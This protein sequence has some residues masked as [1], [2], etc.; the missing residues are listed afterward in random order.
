MVLGDTVLYISV[1]LALAVFLALIYGQKKKV[2]TFDWHIK[3]LIRV[4]SALLFFDFVLLS[5]YFAKSNFTIN[6][7]WAFSS[8]HYPIYYRLSGALAGQQGTLLFWAALIAIGSLWLNETKGST[9][10][11][12]KK[13]QII[14]VFLVAYFA[15]L[16]LLDSPFKTIYQ[17]ASDL[18]A[19]FVPLDGNGLNP[20]L[21]DPWMALHPFTTF[22]AYAGTTIPLAGAIVYLLNTFRGVGEK[23]EDRMWV[24]K[25]MQW[26]RVSWLFA[27]MSMAMGGLWAYKSLGWGG[28]W[29][30]DPVE[31]AMFLPW[32]MLTAAIHTV[33]EHRRDR[34]KYNILAPI[35]VS[36]SFALVIYATMVTRSGI[37]ESV[38]SF[39]AGDVGK[40]IIVLTAVSFAIPL[41]LGVIKYL[42]TETLEREEESIVN[43]TNIFY[44][45]ILVFLIMTFI[46]FFGVTYPP[47]IKLLTTKKHAVTAQFFNIWIYPFFILMLLLIGLGLQYRPSNRKRAVSDFL[48]FSGLT[49]VVS[50]IKPNEY[51]NIVDYTAIVGPSKPLL[52]R[53]IGSISAL[54]VVPPSIYIVYVAVDRWKSRISP[55]TTRNSKIKELGILTIHIGV[56][57][58]SLGIVFASLFGSNFSVTL[59]VNDIGK[60]TNI[61]PAQVHEGFGRLGTWGVHE[62]EGTS[63]Y[64]VQ[65]LDY[66]EIEDYG[67][68]EKEERAPPPGIGISEFY[69]ELA[70][71]NFKDT[72]TVRGFIGDAINV[73][74]YTYIK[75]VEGEK[76]LWLAI[77]GPEVRRNINIVATGSAMFN[78][79]SP[80]LNRTFDVIIFSNHLEE[81]RPDAGGSPYKT[82]QQVKLA[83]YKH[84]GKIGEGVA[85]LETYE[86]GDARR[87]LIDM[88]LVRDVFV[89]FDG[90]GP[91]GAIPLTVKLKPLM[92]EIWL[93]VMLF[94][95]GI[96]M[97]I[98]TD[99]KG[100]A[101]LK[102]EIVFQDL[103][104]G[105]GGCAAVCPEKA[106]RVD[107]FPKLIGECT[108]CSY[109]LLQ[110]PRRSFD[111]KG[112][113]KKIHGE[114]SKDLLGHT[115]V[116]VGARG[117]DPDIRKGA[118]DGAFVTTLLKYA[119]EK[120]II[121]G[122]LV[123]G[124]AKDWRPMPMLV[125]SPE[126][127]AKTAGSKYTNSSN[128]SP[129]LKAK[130]K[131]LNK[132]ALVGLPCQIEG[133]KKMQHCPIEDVDLKDR[134]EF[135]VALFCNGSFLYDGLM[136]DL[137]QKEYSI[138]LKKIK[139]INIKGKNVI[140]TT[141]K[142]EVKIPLE[143]ANEHE[144]EGCKVCHDFTS[145]LSDFSAGSVGTPDGYTTVLART[146]KAAALLYKMEEEGVIE[147]IKNIDASAIERLQKAKGRRAVEMVEKR[148]KEGA[149]LAIKIPQL[150]E[151]QYEIKNL[152]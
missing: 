106:V 100:F 46:P 93:G 23:V 68:G 113:E 140:V 132:L 58:V 62:G 26:L 18:P 116:R 25:G 70:T 12:V 112:V 55:F 59:N 141:D 42:K 13:S 98:F 61:A 151:E 60:I 14:V 79:L 52:Y 139:K 135:T 77:G 10:D 78:F 99:A 76:E 34:E 37:F 35:L 86:N 134:V 148:M 85:K 69:N 56:V 152:D 63:P 117:T 44:A 131:G 92:N 104:C 83:I 48:L 147:T 71:G 47:I 20:L 95:A 75:L 40:Y 22:L 119:L 43:R 82:T 149:P 36:F 31:T 1:G 121:D 110:C 29:A 94:I 45:A 136:R 24:S 84:N 87:A 124:S 138:N 11:F 123:A 15:F 88:S 66:K 51:F 64:S 50:L 109:C 80:S 146:K 129:L 103:C 105:C 30:W 90:L 120:G 122:A 28:F 53:I 4:F 114:V 16:T 8:K 127:L 67:A 21:L 2:D 41:V 54:T 144:R 101:D 89:I 128:L 126:Q 111:P 17:V 91:G 81:Y 57:L 39:I 19:G 72:Y 102:Q 143:K 73:G 107:E 49:V 33:V 125:T 5:Y 145:R 142:G 3:W 27:T 65:L 74:K 108:D 7:V 133:L 115:E 32:L 97:T 96:L 137:I 118:Q 6:Y 150:L 9:S 130:E 38:H